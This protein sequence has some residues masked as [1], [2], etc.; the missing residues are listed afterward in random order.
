MYAAAAAAEGPFKPLLPFMG[1]WL[2]G[3]VPPERLPAPEIDV[4]RGG[5][6][7]E[8]AILIA[9]GGVFVIAA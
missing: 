7:F 3:D 5:N 9:V 2:D 1:D 6:A 4:S 8:E